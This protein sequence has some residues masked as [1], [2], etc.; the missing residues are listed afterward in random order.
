MNLNTWKKFLNENRTDT[1]VMLLLEARVKDIKKKYPLWNDAGW[2]DGVRARIDSTLGP[3]GVSKYLLWVVRELNHNFADEEPEDIKST[4]LRADILAVMNELL[5]MVFKFQENQARIEEKDIYKYKS[6][7][8][9]SLLDKLGASRSQR[10]DKEKKEALQDSEVV[11]ETGD[12]FAV[13]PTTESSSCYFGRNTK[14]CISA[15]KTENWFNKYTEE[16]QRSFAMLRLEHLPED[17]RYKKVAIVYDVYGEFD[18]AF[19][20]WDVPMGYV[21]I[22]N[23]LAENLIKN[24]PGLAADPNYAYEALDEEEQSKID[25]ILEDI[26]Q[27]MA[28]SIEENPPSVNYEEK[29]DA[30][31]EKYDFKHAYANH[32]V[33]DGFYFSGGLSIEISADQLEEGEYQMPSGWREL[34]ELGREIHN[35]L[36]EDS[37]YVEEVDISDYQGDYEIR[38]QA[39][40][41]DYS[42]N[43]EGYD[44]FLRHEITN[45][46]EAYPKIKL[47]IEH[48]LM[49]EGYMAPSAF[50]SLPNKI[51]ELADSLQNTSISYSDHESLGLVLDRPLEYQTRNAT[52]SGALAPAVLKNNEEMITR[53]TVENLQALEL[54]LQAYLDKQ[55]ELPISDLPPR[56]RKEM[57]IPE[58]FR[59]NVFRAN[60]NNTVYAKAKIDFEHDHSEELIAQ[61]LAIA[62]FIEENFD[63][64]NEAF[65]EAMASSAEEIR[66]ATHEKLRQMNPDAYADVTE[67]TGDAIQD[68]FNS[69]VTERS[70]QYGI[71]E[72]YLML[73][74]IHGEDEEGKI[75]G[76]EHIVADIR[77]IPSVTVVSVKVKN[78]KISETDYIA[79]LK[80][81]FIPSLPGV[82][83]S[84]EDAKIKILQ[85]IKATKG[86]RKIFKVSPRFEKSTI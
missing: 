77:A 52:E 22:Q 80:I 40:I 26:N 60:N 74:Y 4:H 3:K 82:L 53:R 31:L 38:L 57:S 61:G 42:N 81:K 25:E 30:I 10:D 76:L 84:P 6:D 47:I 43:P 19:D 1:E 2:I 11:Y 12:V 37:I 50:A 70:R 58:T 45:L 65:V 21:E 20:A 34:S 29:A 15:T 79:G 63:K 62:K 48:H 27:N 18:E 54:K 24:T 13:R 83:R 7:E 44:Q 32:E 59:L 35:K 5:D 85:M 17:H 68:Y 39:S 56:V 36:Y 73:G 41:S 46:D 23:A 86:V 33:Y 64:L 49:E 72:F 67:S 8:L 16:D 51:K 14:W 9:Q 69:L 66:Q 71:Y 78:Q 28:A 55:L 75:R